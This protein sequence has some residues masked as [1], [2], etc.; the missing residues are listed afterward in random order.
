MC[1]PRSLI[2]Q[3]PPKEGSVVS[4]WK[5]QQLRIKEYGVVVSYSAV[6]DANQSNVTEVYTTEDGQEAMNYQNLVV[7]DVSTLFR[8]GVFGEEALE[9][10]QRSSIVLLD[11]GDMGTFQFQDDPPTVIEGDA[12]QI[13]AS[14]MDVTISRTVRSVKRF[15]L[16]VPVLLVP[17]SI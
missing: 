9:G 17:I 10:R 16:A 12:S 3:E 7:E 13:D 14:K 11:D 1:T 8:D 5:A 2:A 4:G 6:L 15:Q